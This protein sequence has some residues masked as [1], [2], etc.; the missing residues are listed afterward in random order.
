MYHASLL[1]T[2]LAYI[3]QSMTCTVAGRMQALSLLRII[4]VLFSC[5]DCPSAC[6][7]NDPVLEATLLVG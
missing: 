3:D 4:F 7:A 2:R 6:R 5:R 1:V